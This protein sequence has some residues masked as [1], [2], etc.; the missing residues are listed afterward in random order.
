MHKILHRDHVL[1][2]MVATILKTS[3]AIQDIAFIGIYNTPSYVWAIKKQKVVS[4]N[5]TP[6]QKL[7][8]S[9]IMTDS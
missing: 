8:K 1:L 2:Q 7:E 4:A 5:L 9:K 3:I 6:A